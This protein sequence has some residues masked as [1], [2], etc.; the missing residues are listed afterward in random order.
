MKINFI[1]LRNLGSSRILSS[2][3]RINPYLGVGNK[4]LKREC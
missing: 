3:Q 1:K 4:I 2:E